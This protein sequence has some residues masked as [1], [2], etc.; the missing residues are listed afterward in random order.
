[1]IH[2]EK[3]LEIDATPEAVWGEISRYMN[4]DE[5]APFVTK[6]DALTEG[7]NGVGSIR[8]NHFDNG[9][10]MVE[11]VIKWDVNRGYRVVSSEFE[12]MPL[13]EA[14]AELAITPSGQGKAKVTWG[15]DYTVKYGPLGWILGQT[16]MK[17]MMGKVLSANLDA[18]ADKVREK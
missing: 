3:S 16:M 10:S 4:I 7:E 8:R 2:H 9:S 15:M 14:F 6:V 18:L 5:F 13:K 1:M 12:P 11:E 17:M